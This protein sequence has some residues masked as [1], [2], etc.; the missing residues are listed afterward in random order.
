MMKSSFPLATVSD[1]DDK[2]EEQE[3]ATVQNVVRQQ[4]VHE[5]LD[6]VSVLQENIRKIMSRIGLS[7]VDDDPSKQIK[8]L[9]QVQFGNLLGAHPYSMKEAT[10]H[11]S[12][13]H[14]KKWANP[15]RSE[16]ARQYVAS[17]NEFGK[18]FIQFYQTYSHL[19]PPGRRG[20]C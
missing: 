20:K 11:R 12:E 15:D 14:I 9:L 13:R 1:D 6:S 8:S 10:S 19:F 17:M 5:K 7:A 18:T 2:W 4:F 3:E 16:I